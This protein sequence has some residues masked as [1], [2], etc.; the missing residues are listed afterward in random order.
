MEQRGQK[1]PE[2]LN[3]SLSELRIY[4]EAEFVIVE[5]VKRRAKAVL[6]DFILFLCL[7]EECV[8]NR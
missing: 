7:N 5:I 1:E 8:T 4:S 3:I 2:Y 6:L